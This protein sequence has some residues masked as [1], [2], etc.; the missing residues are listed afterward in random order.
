MTLTPKAKPV[1]IRI[2]SGGEEHSSIETLR[3]NFSL[4]DILPRVKDGQ[5]HK[6]LERIGEVKAAEVSRNLKGKEIKFVSKDILALTSVIF[7]SAV[8]STDDLVGLLQREY[9]ISFYNYIKCDRIFPNISSARQVYN[10]LKE[11]GKYSEITDKEWERIFVSILKNR[12]LSEVLGEFEKFR[13]NKPMN[14][15]A[16]SDVLKYHSASASD[17]DL[18]LIAKAAYEYA[19]MKNEAIEWYMQSAKTYNKAKEWVNNNKHLDPEEEE[20]FDTFER[21][22]W[23]FSE[24]YFDSSYPQDLGDFLSILSE[25]YKDEMKPLREQIIGHGK[26]TKYLYI[27][28]NLYYLNKLRDKDRCISGLKQLVQKVS[29][30]RY[31]KEYPTLDRI[32][33]SL[34]NEQPVFGVELSKL[35]YQEALLFIE[36][37]V[38]TELRNGKLCHK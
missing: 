2:V 26:Y 31:F 35:D 24:L 16:W 33:Y 15:K 10:T 37:L 32:I 13:F 14:D 25:L 8:R 38:K 18:Y 12:P 19:G 36:N 4:D 27:I 30:A 34:E 23:K 1:R 3:K 5:F 29:I 11:E 20:L 22:P 6:W 28:S 17:E 9:P 21:I 7:N